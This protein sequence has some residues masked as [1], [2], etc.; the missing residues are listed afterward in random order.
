[1]DNITTGSKLIMGGGLAHFAQNLLIALFIIL[2]VMGAARASD[3]DSSSTS[4]EESDTPLSGLGEM[5]LLTIFA[6][7]LVGAIVVGIGLLIFQQDQSLPQEVKKPAKIAGALALGWGVLTLLWRFVLPLLAF[8]MFIDLFD[9]S[10]EAELED[11]V[12]TIRLIFIFA[13]IASF[14]LP[15]YAFFL[16]KFFIATAEH[17]AVETKKKTLAALLGG[18]VINMASNL[19]WQFPML[20]AFTTGEVPDVEGGILILA[21]FL[22]FFVIPFIM[23]AGCWGI[24]S[25]GKELGNYSGSGGGGARDWDPADLAYDPSAQGQQQPYAGGQAPNLPQQPNYFGQQQPGASQQPQQQ[26]QTQPQGAAVKNP[27][28]GCGGELQ[29][30]HEHSQWYCHACQKYPYA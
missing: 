6:G 1:M 23:L 20:S 2:I 24:F 4:G 22:K 9:T 21:V 29:Y 7:D 12:T 30:V 25:A 10:K 16:R 5:I 19:V 18:S 13:I 8:G 3:S 15:A 27:C 26:P 17:G 28:P 14:L 11:I